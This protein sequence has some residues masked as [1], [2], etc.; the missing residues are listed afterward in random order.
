MTP[1]RKITQRE[2]WL[3]C[4]LPAALVVIVSM[5][6]PGPSDEI[7]A[8][9]RRLTQLTGGDAH[10]QI[11]SQLRELSEQR[12]ASEQ[13]LA[14]LTAREQSLRSQLAALQ[15]P[16]PD[17]AAVAMAEALDE[18]TG[19]LAGYGVQVLAM[20]QAGSTSRVGSARSSQA[21][22]GQRSGYSGGDWQVSVAARWPAIRAALADGDAFPPG[23]ALSAMR[24]ESP[25][26]NMP[27]RRWELI[28]TDMQATP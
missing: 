24:M 16:R 3:I 12:E 22:A 17:R 13:D 25:R 8:V 27:L 15:S 6:L 18:L 23:L 1:K 9:E 4:L 7:E 5:A 11:H 19:R 26:P 10:E 2:L 20:E 14:A 21:G 28:V